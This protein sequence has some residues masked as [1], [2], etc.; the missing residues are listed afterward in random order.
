M[1]IYVKCHLLPYF[2]LFWFPNM[3]L[4]DALI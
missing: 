4:T 1:E 3:I 2:L